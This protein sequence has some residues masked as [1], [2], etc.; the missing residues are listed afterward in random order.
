M[1]PRTPEQH[2]IERPPRGDGRAPRRPPPERVLYAQSLMLGDGLPY[3]E[4]RDALMAKFGIEERTAARDIA[5][6]RLQLEAINR[7]IRPIILAQETARKRRIADKAEDSG[8]LAVAVSAS[9]AIVKENG[10]GAAER[11]EHTV[12]SDEQFERAL[13]EMIPMALERADTEQLLAEIERRRE[14]PAG[15]DHG[16]G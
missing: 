4:A 10:A 1:P 2:P 6:M 15:D 5:E 11:I 12:I 3:G 7:E 13:V 14:L 9:N 8:D 16:Q